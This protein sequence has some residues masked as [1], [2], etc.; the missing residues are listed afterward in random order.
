MLLNPRSWMS[1]LSQST[2]KGLL[3]PWLVNGIDIR[4]GQMVEG[5]MVERSMIEGKAILTLRE[6]VPTLPLVT[7]LPYRPF[8][9]VFSPATVPMSFLSVNTHTETQR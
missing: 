4:K 6:F 8:G 5:K 7:F 1:Q 2:I 3:C 9:Y